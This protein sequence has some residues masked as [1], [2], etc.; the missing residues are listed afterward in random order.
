MSLAERWMEVEKATGHQWVKILGDLNEACG[1]KYSHPWVS[2]LRT[3]PSQ[4]LPR[5]VRQYM[6]RKVL[7]V[8]LAAHGLVLT[9]R[10]L[11]ALVD[12]LS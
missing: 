7:P 11:D 8:L 3:R 2:Q 9:P 5:P 6:L 4:N 12:N 10:K 1:T